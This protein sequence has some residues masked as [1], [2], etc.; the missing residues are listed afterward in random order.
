MKL[1][2]Y[3]A[4]AV[5]NCRSEAP[6]NTGHQLGLVDRIS[7]AWSRFLE[8]LQL[9]W[10]ERFPTPFVRQPESQNTLDDFESTQAARLEAQDRA[11]DRAEEV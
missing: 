7:Q 2:Y 6:S 11:Q 10:E 4:R 9:A 1:E 8:G 5:S 3:L